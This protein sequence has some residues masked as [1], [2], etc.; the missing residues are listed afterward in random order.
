VTFVL[1]YFPNLVISYSVRSSKYRV[2]TGLQRHYVLSRRRTKQ[3]GA[4]PYDAD[5]DAET[6][7]EMTVIISHIVLASSLLRWQYGVRMTTVRTVAVRGSYSH[8]QQRD[9]EATT[10]R[11]HG[12]HSLPQCG[13]EQWSRWTIR[14]ADND[15]VSV[16]GSYW[17]QPSPYHCQRQRIVVD[18]EGGC[19]RR[20]RNHAD[21]NRYR[22]A[23]FF[24][25]PFDC[26]CVRLYQFRTERTELVQS[27]TLVLCRTY[28][29]TTYGSGT[30]VH[31]VGLEG[32]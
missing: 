19:C 15:T 3:N 23:L 11:P 14:R 16:S 6:V 30:I 28:V 27:Y 25:M 20:W 18:D 10:N 13:N 31:V 12:H 1:P 9:V 17:Y 2:N 7:C 24:L 8:E 26:H 5:E 4:T 29:R 32:K 22:A 21:G